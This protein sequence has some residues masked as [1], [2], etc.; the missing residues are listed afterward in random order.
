MPLASAFAAPVALRLQQDHALMA[1]WSQ[2]LR[3][4]APTALLDASVA[5]VLSHHEAAALL[6]LRNQAARIPAGERSVVAGGDWAIN[7]GMQRVSEVIVTP[8]GLIII[9]RDGP[10]DDSGANDDNTD[11]GLPVQVTFGELSKMSKKCNA[12]ELYADGVTAPDK[13]AGISAETARTASLQPHVEGAPPTA[14]L[15]GFGMHRFKG[16]TDPGRDTAAKILALGHPRGACLDVCTG[17][18]VRLI[19]L[20]TNN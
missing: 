16:D 6:K 9:P 3:I 8:K 1:P 17:L 2:G 7:L 20:S 15:G 10:G 12:F 5:C 4:C 11:E 19:F 13:I 18:G 14:V